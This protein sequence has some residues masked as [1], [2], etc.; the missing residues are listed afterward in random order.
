MAHQPTEAI[1][2]YKTSRTSI[3]K[4]IKDF[5]TLL[6]KMGVDPNEIL[7][8]KNEGHRYV[9]GKPMRFVFFRLKFKLCYWPDSEHYL[10]I[11]KTLNIHDTAI[12]NG[13][14]IYE[15]LHKRWR[16]IVNGVT[17]IEEAFVGMNLNISESKLPECAIRALTEGPN[18]LYNFDRLLGEG[19]MEVK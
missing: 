10:V 3:D 4:L 17:T 2:K 13:A 19:N 14:A 15:W 6:Y 7:I 12:A 5:Y 1:Q 8:D 18:A 16:A 9:D 11:E